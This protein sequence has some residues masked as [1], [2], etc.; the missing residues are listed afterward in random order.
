MDSEIGT[1][2]VDT[3]FPRGFIVRFR[4]RFIQTKLGNDSIK[5]PV[6]RKRYWESQRSSLQS[7]ILF[8]DTKANNYSSIDYSVIIQE[9]H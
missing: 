4:R 7:K 5:L 3:H 1:F 2:K 6:V 9:W 8:R